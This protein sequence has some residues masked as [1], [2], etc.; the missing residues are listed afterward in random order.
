MHPLNKF[1][2]FMSKYKYYI[3]VIGIITVKHLLHL[4]I[5]LLSIYIHM[6]IKSIIFYSKAT[7]SLPAI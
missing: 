1:R 3:I 5:D 2:I 6:C 7:Q 4:V